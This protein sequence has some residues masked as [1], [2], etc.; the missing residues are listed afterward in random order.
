MAGKLSTNRT[1]SVITKHIAGNGAGLEGWKSFSLN[2]ACP[3]IA[4]LIC[5]S[6]L[7]DLKGVY[8]HHFFARLLYYDRYL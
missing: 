4:A 7:E 3:N 6:Q 8:C 2:K 1:A 5:S